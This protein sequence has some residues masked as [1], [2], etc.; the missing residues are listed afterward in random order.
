MQKRDD[1]VDKNGARTERLV[2]HQTEIIR[3]FTMANTKTI[4]DDSPDC[5]VKARPEQKEP[6]QK[7]KE[8]A[9]R[10]A[11]KEEEG[12]KQ[13]PFMKPTATKSRAVSNVQPNTEEPSAPSSS[14]QPRNVTSGGQVK[15]ARPT[16]EFS[17][18]VSTILPF[19]LT[20]I[21]VAAPPATPAA[22]APPNVLGLPV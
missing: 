15:Q 22:V 13:P 1:L 9:E 12:D 8:E 21:L 4:A 6:E 16:Q 18:A 20:P 3:T 17:Y 7:Q 5:M 19:L 10:R 14:S 2:Q 11:K